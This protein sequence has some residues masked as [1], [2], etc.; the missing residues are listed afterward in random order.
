MSEWLQAIALALV[1]GLTEFLP[2]SSSAHLL[3]PSL[4]L[5]WPDQGLAFDVAVHF[6][7]LLAVL[8][9]FRSDLAA[10]LTGAGALARGQF[11]TQESREL[12]YLAVATVPAVLAGFMLKDVIGTLRT[13]PV[14]STTTILFAVVLAIADRVNFTS[15]STQVGSFW[16][17]LLIGLAQALALIPGTSRSGITLSAALFLGLTR[18]AAARFS[19]LL[20]IPVITGAAIL[21]TVDLL[22]SPTTVNWPLLA[23]ALT[24]A[25][26]VAY[27]TIALFIRFVERVGMMPFVVYRLLL[28][29]ALIVII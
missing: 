20:S 18:K 25:A 16:V 9:Y 22:A 21:A 29:C 11:D 10:L 23:V 24:V 19:F 5:G 27:L 4:L 17:A 6:G 13:I 3:F 8:W 14:I 26:F 12:V 7:T 15:R 1:Q 2:V 28:G